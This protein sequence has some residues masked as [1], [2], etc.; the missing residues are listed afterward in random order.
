[1]AL[2]LVLVDTWL[3]THYS[4]HKITKWRSEELGDE[5]GRLTHL[6]CKAWE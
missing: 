4:I 3:L 1:M 5:F 2:G 6:E